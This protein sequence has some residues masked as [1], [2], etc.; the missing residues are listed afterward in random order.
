[1]YYTHEEILEFVQSRSHLFRL[2][3]MQFGH[4]IYDNHEIG[5]KMSYLKKSPE[6]KECWESGFYKGK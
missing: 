3:N 4:F 2:Y 1:M 6:R 5:F